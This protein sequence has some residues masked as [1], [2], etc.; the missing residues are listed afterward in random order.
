VISATELGTA[1]STENG[2]ARPCGS[3]LANKP[4]PAVEV[5]V[6]IPNWNCR[7]L[8]RK[9]LESLLRQPQGVS[10][11][12]IVVDN[13]STDGA[14]EM[15]AEEFPEVELIRNATNEG[16]SR[17]NN[18]AASAARG[19]FLFFLNNDTVVPA[20]CLAKL[21]AYA[22]E[23]PEA[24]MFGPR[25]RNSDGSFQ[26]SYRRRPS[27]AAMLHRTLLLRWTG[28]CR[29][30]YRN[31]RRESY[32]P[33]Y[34]G[35]IDLLMGAAVFIPRSVF[36]QCGGWDEDFAFGGEDLEF[37]V[38][39]GS[40]FPVHFCPDV[41]VIH[42]GRASSRL[43]AGFC[44]ESLAIGWIHCL[45]KTGASRFALLAYKAV[46]TID[47]PIQ[48]LATWVQWSARRLAGRH[49]KAAKSRITLIGVAHFLRWSL[50]KFWRA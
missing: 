43:N 41:D 18:T 36:D 33:S 37:A 46:V 48:L 5:S 47:S 20:N 12:I 25:L 30:A 19:R 24:G 15:I 16:F 39:V 28:L 38:R 1:N 22:Q 50:P 7:E 29:R 2:E 11:E 10:L 4:E 45:R 21:H 17:A 23:H 42:H 40:H 6:C 13:G 9:C 35:E 34:R 49:A 8:V 26:I 31:Y 44:T 14:P 27:V 32:D 3:N